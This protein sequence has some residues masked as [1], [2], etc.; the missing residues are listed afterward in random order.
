MNL[1][2][3]PAI[4]GFFRAHNTGETENFLQ[5]FTADAVVHDEAHDHRGAAIKTWFDGAIAKYHPQA[6]VTGL[7]REGEQAIVAAQVSGTFPGSPAELHYKFT[8]EDDKIAA[9]AIG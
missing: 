2:L 4:A 3:P 7:T 1:E 6:E 5:L 8:L 9:L